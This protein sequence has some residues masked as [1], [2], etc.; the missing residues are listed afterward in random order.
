MLLGDQE[1]LCEN[2]YFFGV[3]CRKFQWFHEKVHPSIAF[4]YCF[5]K[6][7]TLQCFFDILQYKKSNTPM[8]FGDVSINMQQGQQQAQQQAQQQ[9]QQQGQQQE[10]QQ[11][12]QQ[13]QQHPQG[14]PKH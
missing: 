3:F 1:K 7:A 5:I 14:I 12:Q 10:Q 11:G 13:G 2:S 9:G 8:L 4:L 6:N